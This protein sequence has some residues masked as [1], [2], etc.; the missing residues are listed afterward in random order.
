MDIRPRNPTAYT[1]TSFHI[2]IS[3]ADWQ[4]EKI[5]DI[6]YL[7]WFS[8]SFLL[9]FL[10]KSCIPFYPSSITPVFL[11]SLL[12]LFAYFNYIPPPTPHPRLCFLQCIL[13]HSFS[14]D[15]VFHFSQKIKKSGLEHS[16][17][18]SLR[19]GPKTRGSRVT[20]GLSIYLPPRLRC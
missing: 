8:P 4:L 10:L 6:D 13:S 7:F 5:S 14:I 12:P 16:C 15:T 2:Y 9:H 20:C 1:W 17:R 11:Y 18:I 19:Q 3:V